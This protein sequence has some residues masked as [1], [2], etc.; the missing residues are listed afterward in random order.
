V[1][2]IAIGKHAQ[3][4]FHISDPETAAIAIFFVAW[5]L[6]IATSTALLT[7]ASCI[8]DLVLGGGV[9]GGAEGSGTD[10]LTAP[11][12]LEYLC[13]EG[14]MQGWGGRGWGGGAQEGGYRK[15]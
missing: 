12:L 15:Q 11:S 4:A 3:A 13:V 9:A 14:E 10:T 6:A 7:T 5:G 8:L 2:N 1:E